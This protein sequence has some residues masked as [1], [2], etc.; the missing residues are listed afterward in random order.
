[1]TMSRL[2]LCSAILCLAAAAPLTAADSSSL[3]G[4]VPP[5]RRLTYLYEV[6]F[7][8]SPVAWTMACNLTTTTSSGLLLRLID[9]DALASSNQL[10]PDAVNEMTLN[11]QGTANVSLSGTY[12]GVREFVVE[13]ET[14]TGTTGS[15]YSGALTVNAGTITEV[16]SDQLRFERT[17]LRTQVG[18]LAFWDREVPAGRLIPAGVELDF[19]PT[20][21]T[22]FVRFEGGGT[23]LQRMDLIDVTGGSSQTLVTL[24]NLSAGQATTVAITRSGRVT[25]RVHV[26]G[27]SGGPGVGAWALTPPSGIPLRA[28]NLDTGSDDD[29]SCS[30][31]QGPRGAPWLLL[32]GLAALLLLWLRRYANTSTSRPRMTV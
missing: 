24:T 19:G 13:I 3:S 30:T 14:A 4:T 18:R 5:D 6:D 11:G 27:S 12:S 2:I 32:S 9:L 28:T 25:L 17:G 22:V 10:S 1:M 7:G 21:R 23:S 29:D 26:V 16:A 31:G 20:E 8:S 15:T